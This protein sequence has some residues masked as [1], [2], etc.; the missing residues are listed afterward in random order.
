M[1]TFFL[2]FPV[3]TCICILLKIFSRTTYT[4]LGVLYENLIFLFHDIFN[5]SNFIMFTQ[6][7]LGKGFF[8]STL[9]LSKKSF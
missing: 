3:H 2:I 6:Y 4:V 8:E 9:Y 7:D 1:T 5:Y